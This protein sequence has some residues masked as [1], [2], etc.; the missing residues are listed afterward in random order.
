M[1]GDEL[2]VNTETIT[3]ASDDLGQIATVL[4]HI[5]ELAKT[6]LIDLADY[7][8]PVTSGEIKSALQHWISAVGDPDLP[9]PDGDTTMIM[10][11]R[12]FATF[13]QQVAAAYT[14]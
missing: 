2:Y 13:L 4:A 1:D 5:S 9:Q 7:D 10:R 14:A 8:T 6:A 3:S 12:D 11:M